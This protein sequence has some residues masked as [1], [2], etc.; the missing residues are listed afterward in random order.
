MIASVGSLQR[1][2]SWLLCLR[3]PMTGTTQ[4]EHNTKG[5]VS[6]KLPPH[7]MALAE[8]DQPAWAVKQLQEVRDCKE[9]SPFA[10]TALSLPFAS[11]LYAPRAPLRS[12]R[13]SKTPSSLSL[14]ALLRGWKRRDALNGEGNNLEKKESA[15][16]FG[17]NLWSTGKRPYVKVVH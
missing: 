1:D 5:V 7:W 13:R 3:Y 8:T 14:H 12:G 10:K 9:R 17:Q 6:R 15:W 4:E 2:W 11:V 16:C